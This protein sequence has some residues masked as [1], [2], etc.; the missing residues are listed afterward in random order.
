MVVGVLSEVGGAATEARQS[1]QTV[2]AASESE[3][4]AAGN[5]YSEV[6]TFLSKVA[7]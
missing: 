2:L 6:E 5:L 7:V 4:T 3:E 1:A